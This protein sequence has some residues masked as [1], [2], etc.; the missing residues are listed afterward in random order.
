M[1]QGRPE[2]VQGRMENRTIRFWAWLRKATD[3][4]SPGGREIVHGE[5]VEL[6][7]LW[8]EDI[9]DRSLVT[10]T[11]RHVAA[12]MGGADGMDSFR[13]ETSWMERQRTRTVLVPFAS[14]AD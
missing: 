7:G 3:P 2:P 4:R 8:Q 5:A 13:A 11:M 6:V 14:A 10:S 9:P 1:A 12:C